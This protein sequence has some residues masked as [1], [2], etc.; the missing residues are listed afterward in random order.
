MVLEPAYLKLL[1]LEA[2][3]EYESMTLDQARADWSDLQWRFSLPSEYPS[4]GHSFTVGLFAEEEGP[5]N[6]GNFT[7]RQ[8]IVGPSGPFDATRRRPS[9][10]HLFYEHT[11]LPLYL[12]IVVLHRVRNFVWIGAIPEMTQKNLSSSF[13]LHYGMTEQ[14]FDPFTVDVFDAASLSVPEDIGHFLSQRATSRYLHCPPERRR[15][16]GENGLKVNVAKTKHSMAGIRSMKRLMRELKMEF[17][18]ACGT[19]LGWLRQCHIT[20]YTSDT[21]FDTWAKY[22][23]SVPGTNASTLDLVSRLLAQAPAEDLRLYQKFGEP[24]ASQEFSLQ[25]DSLGERFDLFFIYPN[26]T[27]FLVPFHKPPKYGYQVYPPYELCSVALLGAKLLAPCDPETIVRAEYGDN[28]RRPVK[29][30]DYS[31][32]PKNVLKELMV[33]NFT[34]KQHIYY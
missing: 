27:H 16:F 34:E 14:I 32:A 2:S 15:W 31:T 18:I 4:N 21:D 8:R 5:L 22:L 12:H 29:V 9:V 19:L 25:S 13:L 30:W 28:W 10:H 26:G 33:Y 20:P 6:L 3:L 17:W 24:T 23:V 1:H 7:E 11:Q